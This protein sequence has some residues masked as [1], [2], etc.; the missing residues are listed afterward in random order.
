MVFVDLLTSFFLGLLTPL[1]AVCVIPL[2]PGFIAY[3][4]NIFNKDYGRR[5]Y[6]LFGV[7]VALGVI[8][9]MLL[10]GFLFTTLLQISLTNIIEVISPI[11][12]F[13]LGIISILLIFNFDFSSILPNFDLSS[14]SKSPF[15]KAFI[16]GFF[17]GAII[18]PCNPGFISILFARSLLISDFLNSMLNFLLFGFG[19]GFPLIAFSLLSSNY[20]KQIISFIIRN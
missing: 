6:A 4:A 13:I 7:I 1:T 14:K 16:Y 12:F 3:L 5:E 2:Y 20:N 9:F 11:A 18:I 8:T 19:I 10:L 15:G 17:F